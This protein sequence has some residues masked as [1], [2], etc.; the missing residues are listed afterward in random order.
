VVT[1]TGTVKSKEQKEL[2]VNL[3]RAT[4][5]VAKVSDELV[6]GEKEQQ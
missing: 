4:V 3:V 5:G 1:L 2:A 6:I